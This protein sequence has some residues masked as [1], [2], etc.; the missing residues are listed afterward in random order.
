MRREGCGRKSRQVVVEEDG[1]C[2]RR[3]PGRR[4]WLPVYFLWVAEKL[5]ALQVIFWQ[6]FICSS[7]STDLRRHLIKSMACQTQADCGEEASVCVSIKTML[8]SWPCCS[9][10]SQPLRIFHNGYTLKQQPPQK[11]QE[12]I[13]NLGII[14]VGCAGN[15]QEMFVP[16]EVRFWVSARGDTEYLPFFL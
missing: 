7:L 10:G 16:D 13:T 15:M 11:K 14:V 6:G 12:M 2:F 3:E 5:F 8:Q 9:S 4:E 1:V